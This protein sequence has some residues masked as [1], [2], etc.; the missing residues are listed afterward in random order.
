MPAPCRIRPATLDDLPAIEALEALFP[1]D[2]MSRR[3]LRWALT[4]ANATFIVAVIDRRIIGY[5]LN[6]YRRNTRQGHVYSIITHPDHRQQGIADQL[7][8]ALEKDARQ[9]GC[10]GMQLEVQTS[11][12]PA[13]AFYHKRGYK[14]CGLKP[15]YYD[16]GS[17]ALKMG[18]ALQ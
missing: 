13:I 12:R 17:D 4:R 18:K 11:N 9:R 10:T 15:G 1:V 16:N 6:F 8:T 2:R 7:L 3:N 5:G 14:D